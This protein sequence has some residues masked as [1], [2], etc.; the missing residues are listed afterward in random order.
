MNSET[1][2]ECNR[3]WRQYA[4]AIAASLDMAAQCYSA[5]LRGDGAKLMGSEYR[6]R[7]AVRARQVARNALM[8]HQVTH[9]IQDLE[10]RQQNDLAG[11][12]T[13]C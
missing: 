5:A 12:H 8:D 9:L 6:E 13:P 11:H 10:Q 4:D 1:C 7:L 3:L 2:V